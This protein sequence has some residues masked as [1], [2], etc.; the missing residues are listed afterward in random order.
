VNEQAVPSGTGPVDTTESAGRAQRWLRRYRL[1]AIVSTG[2]AVFLTIAGGVVRLTGSGLGCDDWPACNDERFIDVSSG[3]AAIEQINRLFSGFIGVPVLL[4]LVFSFLV[5]G[6]SGLR[7]PAI[8]VFLTVLAN[9]V[10]GGVA[11]R[12]DLHPVLVQSHFLLAMASI[13][14]GM[15]AVARSG[16]RPAESPARRG[17]T[18]L[19]AV[20]LTVLTAGALATGTVVTGTGPHAG[21]E[22]ARRFGF[23][24][25]AVAEIHSV[26][27]LITIGVALIFAYR[28]GRVAP[29]KALSGAISSWLFVGLLQ[30][31]IGYAQ[32]FSGVPETLV[33]LHIALAAFLWVLTMR[34]LLRT[35]T[36]PLAADTTGPGDGA[37]ERSP[38]DLVAQ[39]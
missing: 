29:S 1:A 36:P 17:L 18:S 39:D 37:D 26:T 16:N 22:E 38:A 12:G 27:A 6:R 35:L 25:S 11:V 21:D 24:I 32:Y 34:L 3:H 20:I 15:V 33:G 9:A 7:W 2:G 5:T 31:A 4:L 14:F 8:G 23:D 13:S 10:V 19:V 30:G 28:V